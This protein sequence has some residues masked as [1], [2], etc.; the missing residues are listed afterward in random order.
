VEERFLAHN[1][2][3]AD[4][5][6]HWLTERGI[7]ALN[8]ISAPGTGKTLLLERTLEALRG[9]VPC[10]VV[11]GDLQTDRDARRLRDKGAPV[12]QIETHT[13]CHLDAERVRK[14]LDVVVQQETRLV[15]IENVGNLVCPAG[16]DLGE[17]FKVALLATTEGEDKPLKYPQLFAAAQTVVLTKTD[18]IPHLSWDLKKCRQSI[19]KVHPGVFTFELSAKTGAGM[20]AWVAYLERLAG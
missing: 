13:V 9:R 20:E 14:A 8:L 6:R 12:F 18:L 19:Q 7:V 2:V 11:T 5:N 4:H 17:H 16:L 1:Q 15:F 3:T 10:A